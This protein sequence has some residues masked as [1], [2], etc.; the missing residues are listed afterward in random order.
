MRRATLASCTFES[1]A[2][3]PIRTRALELAS[4][5]SQHAFCGGEMC[6]GAFTPMRNLAHEILR[7]CQTLERA[8]YVPGEGLTRCLER[9]SA[10]VF[11]CGAAGRIEQAQR[12]PLV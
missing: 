6:G 5:P 4:G 1:V 11:H 8:R 12:P 9:R 3:R 2:P 7:G 10:G